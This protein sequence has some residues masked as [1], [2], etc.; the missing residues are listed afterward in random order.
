[1]PQMTH[2]EK[3]SFCSGNNPFF[4]KCRQIRGWKLNLQEHEVNPLTPSV[5]KMIKHTLKILQRYC[6]I[7]SEIEWSNTTKHDSSIIT[8]TN[9]LFL[10]LNYF[11]F[12][13]TSPQRSAAPIRSTLCALVKGPES[14]ILALNTLV[15]L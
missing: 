5:H 10:H 11:K 13:M 7:F 6:H 12:M 9:R 1:M 14:N 15:E 3:L 8:W 2:F 4:S